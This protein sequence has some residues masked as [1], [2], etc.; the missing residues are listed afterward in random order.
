MSRFRTLVSALTV[1]GLVGSF[2]AASGAEVRAAGKLT[3][4]VTYTAVSAASIARAISGRTVEGKVT[5]GPALGGAP[6]GTA[7]QA[8]GRIKVSAS[9]FIPGTGDSFGY[10]QVV[11]QVSATP[12]DAGDLSKG[13]KYALTLLPHSVQLSIDAHY[14]PT[15]AWNPSCV[16]DISQIGTS[17]VMTLTLPNAN[18]KVTLDQ[19]IDYKYCGSLQ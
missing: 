16:G 6:T 15:T 18:V 7:T 13:C 10:E 4:K 14:A 3:R 8:C 12:V 1:C 17:K 5:F 9:K 11:K 19:V 2:S